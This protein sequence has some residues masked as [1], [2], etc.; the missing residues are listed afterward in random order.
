MARLGCRATL[1]YRLESIR[2]DR[3]TTPGAIRLVIKCNINQ[4]MIVRTIRLGRLSTIPFGNDLLFSWGT[5][6]HGVNL[7]CI[8]NFIDDINRYNTKIW[9]RGTT[10]RPTEKYCKH[11]YELMSHFAVEDYYCDNCE[12]IW[13]TNQF[14]NT[15]YPVKW[16]MPTKLPNEQFQPCQMK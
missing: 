9:Y 15:M 12:T 7:S 13:R 10:H 5:L 4:R 2:R 11:C 16:G 6:D 3:I 1:K 14:K 8:S